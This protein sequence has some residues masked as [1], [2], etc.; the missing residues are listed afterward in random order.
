ML[1]GR[2]G[3]TPACLASFGINYLCE[4]TGLGVRVVLKE[5]LPNEL[6]LRDSTLVHPKSAADRE[7]F[8]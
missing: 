4:H 3:F 5:Y 8:E 7:G 2:Q 6:A 1:K